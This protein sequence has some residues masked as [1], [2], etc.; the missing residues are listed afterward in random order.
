MQALIQ[1]QNFRKSRRDTPRDV[2]CSYTVTSSGEVRAGHGVRVSIES[3][4]GL[5]DERVKVPTV[6]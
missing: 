2:N 1:P 5:G 4:A 3:G 6:K